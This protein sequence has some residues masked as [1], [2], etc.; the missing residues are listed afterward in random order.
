V[1][2]PEPAPPMSLTK[3]DIARVIHEAEPAISLSEAVS[4]VDSIF[5]AIKDRL[6]GGEKVMITNFGTFHVVE[7]AARQGINPATGGDLTIDGHRAVAF[8]PAPSLQSS[9]DR[10]PN[11]VAPD[12]AS[13]SRPW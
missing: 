10:G 1:F 11:G 4:L 3:K 9:L 7:R 12:P 13:H 8:R 6:A 2:D 5:Q